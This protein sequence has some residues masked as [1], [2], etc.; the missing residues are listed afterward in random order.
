VQEPVS[1][2]KNPG[3]GSFSSDV[4]RCGPEAALVSADKVMAEWGGG[5]PVNRDF[6]CAQHTNVVDVQALCTVMA[7]LSIGR[8]QAQRGCADRRH[9]LVQ[10]R[11]ARGLGCGLVFVHHAWLLGSLAQSRFTVSCGDDAWIPIAICDTER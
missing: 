6:E 10:L 3:I 1:V 8:G 9:K 2:D 4:E 5:N 7:D 11:L